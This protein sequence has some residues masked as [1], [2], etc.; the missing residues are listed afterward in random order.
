MELYIHRGVAALKP[1]AATLL[2]GGASRHVI[3]I[4]TAHRR[5]HRR[6]RQTGVCV[7]GTEGSNAPFC[8][9]KRAWLCA[10]RRL[11]RDPDDD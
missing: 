7:W 8:S 9:L 10:V 5:R 2:V 11:L 1:V 4:D 3:F 6:S